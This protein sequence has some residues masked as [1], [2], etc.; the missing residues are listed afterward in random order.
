MGNI[1]D[2]LGDGL[3]Q[4]RLAPS[5]RDSGGLVCA[6]SPRSSAGLTNAAPTARVMC[7]GAQREERPRGQES[8]GASLCYP[9]PQMRGTGG[10][11]SLVVGGS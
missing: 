3:K 5:L 9:G 10:T 2:P 11:H 4:F 8:D 1:P 7:G 6:A